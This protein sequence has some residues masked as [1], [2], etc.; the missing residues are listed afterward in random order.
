MRILL[1]NDDGIHAPGI[2][3][4]HKAL[5]GLGEI[6]TIAPLTV[7]SATGHGITFEDP[8]TVDT[9]QVNPDLL[10]YAVD[11]R[12]A[13]CVKVALR[14]LWASLHGPDS[15]PDLVVSGM[16]SG[17][18]VG[19]NVIY[20]GTVA[21][22]IEAAFLGIPAIAVSLHIGDRNRI[23]YDRA[24]EIGRVVIDRILEHSIDAHS[25]INVNVPRTES[26][27]AAM[28]PVHVVEMNTAAGG[29]TY[30]RRT[31]PAGR[32][33]YW[34]CGS[35]LEFD[36]TAKGSDVEALLDRS[37]TVTPLSYDLTDHARM[38]S[39]RERLESR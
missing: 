19:I 32:P 17:A 10:G 30:E 26:P 39:W 27:D 3:A 2:A 36:H 8:L 13:D 12:P 5:Q 9:V 20:S 6:T 28:P 4:M 15:R 33:Y 25:V 37:V 11:G 23:F 29:S 22:A 31:S 21:A 16:N 7:Q 35:G 18:N 1:T 38:N 14:S 24:A 34:A